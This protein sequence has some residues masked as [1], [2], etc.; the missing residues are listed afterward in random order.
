MNIIARIDH[1]IFGH[2][3]DIDDVVED[4]EWIER[5]AL[6][7][8]PSFT[9]VEVKIEQR[10]WTFTCDYC[11]EQKSEPAFQQYRALC[12]CGAEFEGDHPEELKGRL[13][14]H[15]EEHNHEKCSIC[16][17]LFTGEHAAQKKGGH[18][19]SAHYN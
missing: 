13:R 3:F 16:G 11:G 4:F 19:S 2:S 7:Q 9:D 10:F 18:K 17:R 14:D 15:H 12:E 1:A 8:N 6:L 5:G